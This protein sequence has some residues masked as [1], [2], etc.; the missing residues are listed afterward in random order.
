MAAR[1]SVFGAHTAS[2][3]QARPRGPPPWKTAHAMGDLLCSLGLSASEASASA[4]VNTSSCL[5]RGQRRSKQRWFEIQ[6]LSLAPLLRENATQ[7]RN[8]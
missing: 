6:R 3:A 1:L 4:R 8:S 7:L 5:C 2:V